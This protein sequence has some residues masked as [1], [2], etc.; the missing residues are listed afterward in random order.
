MTTVA[1]ALLTSIAFANG[2]PSKAS[3]SYAPVSSNVAFH[4]AALA[5]RFIRTPPHKKLDL[6]A[7]GLAIWVNGTTAS[8]CPDQVGID[9]PPGN[10]T[11]FIGG[12]TSP[13]LSMNV[14]V[15]GGQ[16][17]CAYTQRPMALLHICK[18]TLCP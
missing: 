6:T 4:A 10:A 7:N 5:P 15:P 16:L 13:G 11:S 14:E 8:F 1:A 9:C 17:V 18:L 3:S 12:I 2:L